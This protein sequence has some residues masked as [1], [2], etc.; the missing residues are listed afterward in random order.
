MDA[1]DVIDTLVGVE[2]G[3][4]L[5]RIRA[6]RPQARENAQASYAALFM[7]AEP[8]GMALAERFA[9]AAFVAGL[10]EQPAAYAHYTAGLEQHGNA[11]ITAAV[12]EAIA[13][14][15]TRGPYGAY[16]P[17]PLSAEDRAGPTFAAPPATRDALGGRLAAALDHA[18]LLVFRPRDARPDALQALLDAGWTT[19][20]VV[21]LSQLVA[22]LS[23]QVRVI[24]GLSVLAADAGEPR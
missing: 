21:T 12:A 15:R 14:G 17:G 20:E 19:T 18:H 8:G 9:V 23:F 7:P 3:S 5:D 4:R 1:P 11:A 10:H 24:A 22:F 16:P 13:A 2:P 6:E